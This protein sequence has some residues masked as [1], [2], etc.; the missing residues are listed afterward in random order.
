MF[1]DNVEPLRSCVLA[2]S[3]NPVVV[4]CSV[5][6][7]VDVLPVGDASRGWGWQRRHTEVEGPAQIIGSDGSDFS[8]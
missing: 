3:H 1:R 8:S 7:T 5:L 4:L 2:I 6:N